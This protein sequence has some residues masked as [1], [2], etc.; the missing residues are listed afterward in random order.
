MTDH[1]SDRAA[2]ADLLTAADARD[3]RRT[4]LEAICDAH[5]DYVVRRLEYLTGDRT[6]A[7]DLA[8]E[9]FVRVVL[10]IDFYRGTASLRSWISGIAF[11]LARG[12][13]ARRRRRAA[14]RA[15]CRS[16]SERSV[17]PST[18]EEQLIAEQAAEAL[19]VA[20]ERLSEDQREAFVLR[21]IDQVPLKDAARIL[22]IP[23]STVSYRAGRGEARVRC[24]I[25]DL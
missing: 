7:R 15:R 3:G 2:P 25:R 12:H 16:V 5:Y 20:L 19:Y 13:S 6:L 11:N 24:Y 17:A 18:P 22:G 10:R 9:T 14:L 4:A 21:V 23:E 8:Q 1:C